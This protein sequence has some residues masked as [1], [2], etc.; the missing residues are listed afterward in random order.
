MIRS[1]LAFQENP[2]DQNGVSKFHV[3]QGFSPQ[4]HQEPQKGEEIEIP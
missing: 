3:Q 4:Q 2:G 1:P